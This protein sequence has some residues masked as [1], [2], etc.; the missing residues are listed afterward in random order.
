MGQEKKAGYASF[1]ARICN[2]QRRPLIALGRASR[3]TSLGRGP[4]GYRVNLNEPM[5]R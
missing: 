1:A 2:M 3:I 4:K 5:V